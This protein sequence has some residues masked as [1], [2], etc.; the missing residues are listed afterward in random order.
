MVM[1]LAYL[2]G[3]SLVSVGSGFRGLFS[4]ARGFQLV[5]LST[6]SL[7]LCGPQGKEKEEIQLWRDGSVVKSP[8]HTGTPHREEL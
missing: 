3:F 7:V 5:T 2:A 6:L 1:K 8:C 4:E